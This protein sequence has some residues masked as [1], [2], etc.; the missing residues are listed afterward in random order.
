MSK[1][2]YSSRFAKE[3]DVEQL[4]ILMNS[5]SAL[6]H[7]QDL[8][9]LPATWREHIRQDIRCPSCGAGETQIVS[10][11]TSKRATSPLRQA[12]FRFTAPDGRDAHHPLCDFSPGNLLKEDKESLVDLSSERSGE[13]RFI[14]RLVCIGIEQSHFSQATIR[15]MRQWYFETKVENLFTVTGTV[16]AV[17]YLAKL[18]RM[19]LYPDF[20]PFHPSQ[21]D[22][23]D[24]DWALAA[25]I[26][27][28]R[29]AAGLRRGTARTLL[30]AIPRAKSLIE[31][32]QGREVLNPSCLKV[33][34]DK[35]LKLCAL[36]AKNCRHLKYS[37]GDVAAFRF[38]GA[39]QLLL[40]FCSLLLHSSNWSME[41]AV[42]KLA[43]VLKAPEPT[44]STLGNVIGLNPFHDYLAWE[45]VREASELVERRGAIPDF[46][47]ELQAA[48]DGLRT[49]HTIWKSQQ[50]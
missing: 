41:T 8:G 12:H 21:G 46:D 17:E 30:D 22:L 13:T 39:P 14:R 34:Y 28:A 49:Q 3:L 48:E 6:P 38:R 26:T 10:G 24:F 19:I 25:R 4:L 23:P 43:L 5:G 45:I 7:A 29:D 35:T 27:L 11:A 40:A 37:D 20:I 18:E 47:A 42:T 9:W 31:R 33:P 1:T 44:D 50:P 2:A 36:L 32:Y 15:S 16:E